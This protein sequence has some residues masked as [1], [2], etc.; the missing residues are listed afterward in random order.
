M[1]RM[2]YTGKIDIPTPDAIVQWQNLSEIQL[3]GLDAALLAFARW[4]V[5]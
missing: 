1:V 2:V 5:G 3:K 4:Q